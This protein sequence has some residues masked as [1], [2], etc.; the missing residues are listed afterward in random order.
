MNKKPSDPSY[1]NMKTIIFLLLT[2][3]ALTM[4][5]QEEKKEY[6]ELTPFENYVIVQKGTETAF[7]GKYHD[8]KEAGIYICKRCGAPLY[9]STD[10]FDSGCGWPSFDDEIEGAVKRQTD[11]DGIR[12]ELVCASCGGH[13]GHVFFGEHF[14]EKNTRYCVNS[15]SLDF[16]PADKNKK[17][18]Q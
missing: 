11:A 5:A 6:R 18:G 15:I 10:K 3:F 13:L 16:I 14:T 2:G 17:E 8:Y 9:R 7:S 12:T 4:N 1:E